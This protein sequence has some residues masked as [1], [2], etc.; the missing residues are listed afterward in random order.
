MK[1]SAQYTFLI[2]LFLLT[3]MACKPSG[4][5]II[6]RNFEDQV[7]I[8]Q[9]LEFRFNTAIVS[10][11]LL[12]KWNSIE[13][14]RIDPPISGKF[15]WNASDELVFSPAVR[16][17]PATEYKL[18]LT[19]EIP[20]AGKLS[21]GVD[22]EP[23]VFSTPM[24]AVQSIEGYW[25]RAAAALDPELRILLH[26]NYSVDAAELNSLIQVKYKGKLLSFQITP[27]SDANSVQL[28]L[29]NQAINPNTT[30]TDLQVIVLPG[31]SCT[32][33]PGKSKVE[34]ILALTIPEASALSIISVEHE[35]TPE[36]G[37][38]KVLCNQGVALGDNPGRWF[39]LNPSVNVRVEALD[40]GCIISGD[41][42]PY[43][44]YQL[45]VHAG[46]QGMLSGALA[47]GQTFSMRFEESGPMLEFLAASGIYLSPQSSGNIG[48]RVKG[49]EELELTVA[50]IYENNILSFFREESYS[51]YYYDE[52]SGSTSSDSRSWAYANTQ[53]HGDVIRTRKISVRS[54]PVQDDYRLLNPGL[55]QLKGTKGL[56]WV[57]VSSVNDKWV[58]DAKLI[59]YSD[60]GLLSKVSGDE[61]WVFANSIKS[62]E[63]LAGITVNLISTNNQFMAKGI[64]DAKGVVVLRNLNQ[65]AAGFKPK[66]I[67]AVSGDDF[68]FLDLSS[69]QVQTDRWDDLGG[70][71]AGTSGLLGF[72]YGDR[73]LYRPGDTLHL[74]MLLRDAKLNPVSTQPI[75]VRILL[76]NGKESGWHKLNPGIQGQAF[77]NLPIAAGGMTGTWQAEM[78]TGDDQLLYS[79]RFS[80]E[81]FIPDRIAV[82]VESG[83]SILYLND[84]IE[85]KATATLLYGPPAAGRVWE[86]S[87]QFRTMPLKFKT[88]PGFRFNPESR[89]NSTDLIHTEHRNGSTDEQGNFQ[90]ECPLNGLSPDAGL[91]QVQAFIS[92]ID[93]SGK[94][95]HRLA[96]YQVRTQT[97]FPGIKC[98]EQ[99]V[100]ANAPVHANLIAVNAEGKAMVG[101][102]QVKLIRY[103][104][105]NVVEKDYRGYYNFNPRKQEVLVSD[106]IVKTTAEASDFVF[107]LPASGEY[108]LRVSI[109]GSATYVRMPLYAWAWGTTRSNSFKVNKEGQIQI[110]ADKSITAPGEKT[111]ILFRTPFAGKLLVTLERD[112]VFE[113][114]IVETDNKAATLEINIKSEHVPNVFISATLIKPLDDGSMPLTVAYGFL[115]LKVENKQAKMDLA[116]NAPEKIRSGKPFKFIVKGPPNTD[117]TIAV[118]DEGVLLM[119]NYN[120]PDAYKYF[121]NSR[122]LETQTHSMYPFLFPD[123]K[124][125]KMAYGGD[126]YNLGRRVNPFL[127]PSKSVIAS[128]SGPIRTNS[129]GEASIT[130]D[131]PVYAG[132]VRVMASAWNKSSFGMA[133]KVVKIADPIVLSFSMPPQLAPGDSIRVPVIVSKTTAGSAKAVV[134]L[135][136]GKGLKV[137]GGSSQTIHLIP[138]K[139]Q[140][141]WFTVLAESVSAKTTLKAQIT[142]GAEIVHDNIELA[143]MPASGYT[144]EYLAKEIKAGMSIT[145]TAGTGWYPG[146]LQQTLLAGASPV[147]GLAGHLKDLIQYPYGCLEQTVSAVF[148]QL[149]LATLAE[150]CGQKVSVLNS[151]AQVQMALQKLERM[152]LYHGGFAYWETGTEVSEW[153]SV[154]ATHFIIEAEKAG[155]T[156][157][158]ELKESAIR[159]LSG[160]VR[161]RKTQ[162]D[163]GEQQEN[164]K[165]S[166]VP[167]LSAVYGLYVLASAGKPDRST[168]NYY[169]G[170]LAEMNDLK[171]TLLASAYYFSGDVASAKSLLP[172]EY[173]DANTERESGGE[174]NS[175]IR[176]Q[177]MVLNVFTEIK[178]NSPA[179]LALATSLTRQLNVSGDLSTQEKGMA[180]LALGKF[181]LLKKATPVTATI[182]VGGQRI[183][184]SSSKTE[185]LNQ[186]VKGPVEIS[187]SSGTLYY[188]LLSEGYKAKLNGHNINQGM[189]VTREYLDRNGN[190]LDREK[191][192]R[193]EL[194]VVRISIKSADSRNID[195]V[196]ITDLLPPGLEIENHRI[197]SLPDLRLSPSASQ[198]DHLDIRRDRLFFFTTING[199]EKHF[200]YLARAVWAGSFNAGPVSAECM[201]DA[202]LKSVNGAGRV[203]VK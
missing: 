144:G 45:T 187:V 61:I 130:V 145:L 12:D 6:S 60:I 115:N 181:A 86:A 109:P 111:K 85:A 177:A 158:P 24:P 21:L 137:I 10:D 132:A 9:N 25:T 47:E 97:Y 155:F 196:V 172:S 153:G 49:M 123:L 46:L 89:R 42:Q 178:P 141:V 173:K 192:K 191:I 198:P 133:E 112:K 159:W 77:L 52:E 65:V 22:P 11:S 179:T 51:D 96:E 64:T 54:L 139:E 201:Y 8:Q 202:S 135:T 37:L 7:E 30:I 29:Q 118:V 138:N 92:V 103:L 149:Y 75:K 152:Q 105:Q 147:A 17:N 104:W 165:I 128:W 120:T 175:W 114:H 98:D 80:V 162:Y 107:Q 168:Q 32:E 79:Y 124:L 69:T 82:Q 166:R 167:A 50:R 74:A 73:N 68:T 150:A 14:L 160:L 163:E 157:R 5:N 48:L 66:L 58:R 70:L 101:N 194:I 62:A 110:I 151:Q 87:I 161:N 94:P 174:L 190:K 203:N 113:Y 176:N 95:V 122:A 170:R 31:L 136:P 200:Y 183:N 186:K 59:S 15:K 185:W 44:E 78:M 154:Y 57:K 4:I 72:M 106:K 184:Y 171:R 195:N 27:Q 16:F 33:G 121:Y 53:N 193:N 100:N 126:G 23:I 41:F 40:Y 129:N 71:K 189:A 148:P 2:L 34:Q 119:K 93:E 140:S 36:G 116:V 127:M 102:I 88:W 18:Y 83:N 84:K 146:S 90:F 63:P 125:R 143:I 99:W 26:F 38:I 56:Y 39:S 169:K 20:R 117:L 197:S 156:V 43:T 199:T 164:G 76:P 55:D 81:E 188:N 142:C 108:E 3:L 134:N 131:L 1:K 13:Y 180:L 28:S 91:I 182:S 67:T 35:T 19:D